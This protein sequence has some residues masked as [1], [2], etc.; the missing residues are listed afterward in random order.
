MTTLRFS[1]TGPQQVIHN[2]PARFKVVVAGR[3]F[4]KTIYAVQ[5]CI[6]EGLRDTNDYDE[7]L[8]SSSEVLYIGT[9]LEQARRNA[10]N[11]FKDFARPV[12]SKIHENTVCI[13]LVNGVRIRLLGMDNPDAA[14]GIKS[15]F[16]CL[17]EYAQMPE[18]AWAEIIRP[19]LVDSRGGGLFI[20]TPKGRNHFHK[21]Y[22]E[23]LNGKKG[24]EAFNFA[25]SDNPTIQ[26]D[27]LD[28][29]IEE[30]SRGAE[31]LHEQE[32]LGKF[33]SKGGKLFHVEDFKISDK[34]PKEG[35]WKIA[36]DLAGFST[37]A[38]RRNSEIKKRDET[39]IAIVKVH[40]YGW[41]VKEILHGRW[42]VRE[43]ALRIVKAAYDNQV[44]DVGIE[45]GALKNAVEPYMREYQNQLHG[46][47]LNII[48]LTHGNRLKYD[49]VQWALQG[50]VKKHQIVLNPGEYVDV[51]L[52]QAI[53][54]PSRLTHDDLVDALS[55]I[56]QMAEVVY[57]DMD[58][59]PGDY[60]PLDEV[61]GY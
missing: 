12:A 19:A 13:T 41:W 51:F 47:W 60:Q 8:D 32:I 10:W 57:W 2:S 34:E 42:D 25:T 18:F 26:P 23:A 22:L 28:E 3:R 46:R 31:S 55:Y 58:D 33:V 53:E 16:A 9:T 35:E 5:K 49:R 37:E 27:E 17:D 1:M 15:R 4:G 7:P 36:V 21:A 52:D 43:T 20:G 11:Y 30:Y 56:D 24:W 38:G 39:A 61:S 14:R 40:E 44:A 29:M 59:L 48:P 54:F 45:K 6:L 50:R